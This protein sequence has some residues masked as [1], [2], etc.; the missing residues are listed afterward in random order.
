VLADHVDPAAARLDARIE[1]DALT[2]LEPADAFSER[3]HDAGAVRA[4]DAGLRD[5]RQ[6]L[7]DPDVEVI[8]RRGVQTDEH[9]ARP[10]DRIGSLFEHEYLGTAVVVDPD[11]THRGRLSV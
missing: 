7:A 6:S 11:R 4:E 1:D 3:F 5:G 9:L 10:C 8:E 2:R